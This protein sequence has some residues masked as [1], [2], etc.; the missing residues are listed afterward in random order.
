MGLGDCDFDSG[1]S[2]GAGWPQHTNLCHTKRSQENIRKQEMSEYIKCKQVSSTYPPHKYSLRKTRHNMPHLVTLQGLFG[3]SPASTP[4]NIS[5]SS[6][7]HDLRSPKGP[8]DHGRIP[9]AE[10]QHFFLLIHL[11]LVPQTHTV[12]NQIFESRQFKLEQV[13]PKIRSIE[14]YENSP[15]T[16]HYQT[17][18]ES[19]ESSSK[20]PRA[21]SSCPFHQPVLMR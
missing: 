12:S 21:K 18:T 20:F 15:Y 10:S 16:K 11:T 5:S 8:Q 3:S 6:T 7:G 13:I 2:N 9:A 19:S 1:A 17:A 4:S 14:T